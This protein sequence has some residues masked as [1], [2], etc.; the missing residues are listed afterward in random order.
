MEVPS[1][2]RMIGVGVATIGILVLVGIMFSHG[3]HHISK[4]QQAAYTTERLKNI[5]A[6]AIDDG[7]SPSL[8]LRIVPVRSCGWLPQEQTTDAWGNQVYWVASDR[9]LGVI[10]GGP[11]GRIDVDPKALSLAGIELDQRTTRP[12]DDL[13]VVIRFPIGS[14]TAA[15]SDDSD[16]L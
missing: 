7:R 6:K 10:S 12:W 8:P 9:H 13:V 15:R 5:A 16:A 3:P 2:S 1:L 11:N 4:K 14:E